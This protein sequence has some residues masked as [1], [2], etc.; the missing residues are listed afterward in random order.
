MSTEADLRA[1]LET[2]RLRVRTVR[3]SLALAEQRNA[4]LTA[5]LHKQFTGPNGTAQGGEY[6]WNDVIEVCIQAINSMQPRAL[7]P[8]A[9]DATLDADQLLGQIGDM[10]QALQAAGWETVKLRMLCG[11]NPLHCEEPPA[12]DALESAK[13]EELPDEVVRRA[14]HH[15]MHDAEHPCGPS[16]MREAIELAIDAR[17]GRGG[18]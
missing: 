3:E 15:F 5:D 10:Q 16:A 17:R 13:A 14:Y 9:P 4:P 1:A 6:A 12:A 18:R 11:L 8:A 2:E 7:P